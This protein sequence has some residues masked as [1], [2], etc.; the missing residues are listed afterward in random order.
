MNIESPV[1]R[2][3]WFV[4]GLAAA[5]FVAAIA[6]PSFA[7][8]RFFGIGIKTTVGSGN[9]VTEARNIAAFERVEISDG[10]TATL[11][12]ASAPALRVSADDNIVPL[13]ETKLNGTTLLVRMRPNTSLRTKST[14]AVAI[15]YVKIDHLKVQDG[16]RAD[17]D[18][19]TAASMSV[20]VSDGASAQIKGIAATDVEV[21]VKD[22]ASARIGEITRAER[23][24]YRV[25]DG[26]RLSIDTANGGRSTVVV[27]DG[28]RLTARGLSASSMNVTMSD[29][30]SAQLVGSAADQTYKLN[31]GASLDARD[32]RGTT[33]FARVVDASSLELG[34][35][36]KLDLTV[37]DG[38]S[39]RYT[40]EPTMTVK[41]GDGGSVRKY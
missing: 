9:V 14:I 18:L 1:A 26:A 19:L 13:V 20:K 35:L 33:A 25:A 40:G 17:T 31:D 6:Q 5:A 4:V 8:T 23:Q 11:R 22:G 15:D 21:S 29:G 3:R 10:I 32:L 12:Q 2:E 30:A 34:V 7:E 37:E 16:A 27:K 41:K 28:A 36:Q 39:V 24:S 38:G